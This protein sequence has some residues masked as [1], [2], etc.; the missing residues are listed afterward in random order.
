MYKLANPEE[1]KANNK[2]KQNKIITIFLTTF[3]VSFIFISLVVKNLPEIDVEIGK[4]AE[5]TDVDNSEQGSVDERLRWIQFEDNMPGV[6]T[7]F[8]TTEETAQEDGK[9]NEDNVIEYDEDVK[10]VNVPTKKEDA[11]IKVDKAQPTETKMPAPA[12]PVVNKISKVYVG[13]YT[14]IEQAIAMQNRL[15]E[16][17]LDLA[18][19]V[20]KVGG[21]Y[22][23]QIGSYASAQKAQSVAESVQNAGFAARVVSE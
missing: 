21:N 12:A 13:Q 3:L 1:K 19:F 17:G 6:S 14:T 8:T 23:V 15:T 5:E 18:P 2:E 11:V 7:R 4:N 10:S 16:A 20:K 22:V 9:Q